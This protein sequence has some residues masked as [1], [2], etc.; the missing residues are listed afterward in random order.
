LLVAPATLFGTSLSPLM[1]TPRYVLA[2]FPIFMVMDLLSRNK[3]LFGGWLL[4]STIASLLLCA[5]FVSWRF[6]T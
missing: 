4:L 3:F 2:A 1:G 5:L 6:V